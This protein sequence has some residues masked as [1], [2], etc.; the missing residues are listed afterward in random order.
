MAAELALPAQLMN[1]TP[2][3]MGTAVLRMCLA[4][5]AATSF[6]RV[7][8]ISD[9]LGF[10]FRE[11][12]EQDGCQDPATRTRLISRR[13]ACTLLPLVAAMHLFR[14]GTSLGSRTQVLACA[15]VPRDSQKWA[16]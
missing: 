12:G 7:V 4:R 2:R 16:G 3:C 1:K 9:L 5:P 10:S 8:D 11:E 13:R 14:R 6:P 15:R